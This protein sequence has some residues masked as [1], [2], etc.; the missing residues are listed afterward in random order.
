MSQFPW[1]TKIFWNNPVHCQKDVI[2]YIYKAILLMDGGLVHTELIHQKIYEL[3]LTMFGNLS[4]NLL[5]IFLI[6]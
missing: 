6:N 3:Q 4:V 5:I 2:P 1:L